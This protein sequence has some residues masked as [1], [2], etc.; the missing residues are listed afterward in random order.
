VD[1]LYVVPF[2][3]GV[4]EAALEASK[5]GEGGIIR[6]YFDMDTSPDKTLLRLIR[7]LRL[8]RLTRIIRNSKN[9]KILLR[10]FSVSANGLI[11]F[12]SIYSTAVVLFSGIT[13]YL[14]T[15]SCTLQD[16]T[17]VSICY[18]LRSQVNYNVI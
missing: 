14:E 12:C 4:I 9:I 11:L 10:A 15:S 13:Y 7:I 18:A 6:L 17:F 1:L 2:F 16:Y 5:G 8:F 3:F